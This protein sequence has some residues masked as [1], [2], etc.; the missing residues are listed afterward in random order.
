MC[1][2]VSNILTHPKYQGD[3]AIQIRKQSSVMCPGNCCCRCA[4]RRTKTEVMGMMN[5]NRRQ[6]P[7]LLEDKRDSNIGLRTIS[8]LKALWPSMFPCPSTKPSFIECVAPRA[9]PPYSINVSSRCEFRISHDWGRHCNMRT[10]IC[11]NTQA[12]TNYFGVYFG[13]TIHG[14]FMQ[15]PTQSTYSLRCLSPFYSTRYYIYEV[16][17]LYMRNK[18]GDKAGNE[19]GN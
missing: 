3:T 9:P 14:T 15:H 17:Y 8:L 11:T 5:L 7:T 13:H 2:R 18:A 16:Y 1:V 12:H 10:R 6:Q 19:A 4:F